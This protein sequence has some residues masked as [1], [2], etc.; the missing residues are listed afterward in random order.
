[1]KKHLLLIFT[2]LFSLI[3]FA[4]SPDKNGASVISWG[5]NSLLAM[6][7]KVLMGLISLT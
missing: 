2:F 4:Q 3:L 1:M 5:Q 7:A 6:L